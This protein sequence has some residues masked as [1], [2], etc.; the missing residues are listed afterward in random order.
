MTFSLW[1]RGKE[2]DH[3]S[4]TCLERKAEGGFILPKE[5]GG[6]CWSLQSI[7]RRGERPIL[8]LPHD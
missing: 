6:G 1:K 8:P 3:S 4:N 7:K 5:R 2:K